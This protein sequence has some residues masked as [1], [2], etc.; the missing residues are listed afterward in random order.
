[1]T[2]RRSTSVEKTLAAPTQ[3]RAAYHLLLP[4]HYANNA[5]ETASLGRAS[6]SFAALD[7]S[8]AALRWEHN[9]HT[10]TITHANIYIHQDKE[11][12]EG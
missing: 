10:R 11:K 3:K 5:R 4:L 12:R 8:T 2:I 9:G 7:T 1:M 6:F